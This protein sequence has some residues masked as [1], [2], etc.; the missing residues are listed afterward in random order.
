MIYS[1]DRYENK[2]KDCL[3][4]GGAGEDSVLAVNGQE[5]VSSNHTT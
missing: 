3:E 1:G 5:W 2:N 4:Q